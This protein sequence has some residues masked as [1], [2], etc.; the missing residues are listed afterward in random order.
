[1]R[2]W[3]DASNAGL[4]NVMADMGCDQHDIASAVATRSRSSAKASSDGTSISITVASLW[5]GHLIAR[6]DHCMARL[7]RCRLDRAHNVAG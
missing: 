6:V 7:G 2:I 3:C 5:E 1:V 4:K